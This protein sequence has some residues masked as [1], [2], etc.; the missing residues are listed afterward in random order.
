M[1]KIFF[2]GIGYYK[3]PCSRSLARG[4][5]VKL[6]MRVAGEGK[7]VVRRAAGAAARLVS[8]VEVPALF[9]VRDAPNLYVKNMLY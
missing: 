5:S 7:E 9:D 3:L 8:A 2:V 6:M 4:P 1:C